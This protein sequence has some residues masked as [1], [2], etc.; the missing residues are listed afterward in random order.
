MPPAFF[1][2][3]PPKK[4]RKIGALLRWRFHPDLIS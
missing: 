4:R 1:F 2:Y 3:T